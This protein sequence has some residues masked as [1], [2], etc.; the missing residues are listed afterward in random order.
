MT[1]P[2]RQKTSIARRLSWMLGAIAFGVFALA[3][4]ILDRAVKIVDLVP[5]RCQ[6]P[7]PAG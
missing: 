5:N 7:L 6:I 2:D 3:G 1:V 4:A